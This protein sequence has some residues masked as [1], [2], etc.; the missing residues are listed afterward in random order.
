M[1][2]LKIVTLLVPGINAQGFH[3]FLSAAF[4]LWLLNWLVKPFIIAITLPINILSLGVF[5]FIINGFLFYL[6]P[7]LVEGFVVGSFAKAVLGAFLF[8][9]IDVFLGFFFKAGNF[10]VYFNTNAS[11]PA[12][13]PGDYNNVIDAEVVPQPKDTKQI[14]DKP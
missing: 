2:I 14:S 11:R 7:K 12:P 13:K 4:V 10:K 9:L 8:S 1:V 3:V 5:T 6:I